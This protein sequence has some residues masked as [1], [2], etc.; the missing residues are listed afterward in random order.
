MAGLAPAMAGMTHD[1][2]LQAVREGRILPVLPII[3]RIGQ[4]YNGHVVDVEL[5][6]GIGTDDKSVLVYRLAVVSADGRLFEV[7]VDAPSGEI[8]GVG[9]H[10]VK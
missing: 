3:K 2:A 8:L 6:D 5:R 9:G 1:Q 10:G 7:L 4:K